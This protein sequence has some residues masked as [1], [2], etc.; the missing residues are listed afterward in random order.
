MK[1]QQVKELF[2]I[3]SKK[4]SP[5]P[6][7]KSESSL[8]RNDVEIFDPRTQQ[9]MHHIDIATRRRL[10]TP[11]AS[12]VPKRIPSQKSSK[13]SHVSSYRGSD[14]S[15]KSAPKTSWFKSL[16]RLSRKNKVNYYNFLVKFISSLTR[17]Y[18]LK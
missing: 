14:V 6:S 1:L 17:S 18:V 15:T 9:T 12:P 3:N 7:N 11:K 16:E 10:S 5:P 4:K 2:S 13:I 8:R